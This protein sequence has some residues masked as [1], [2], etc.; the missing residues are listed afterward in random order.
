MK[1]LDMPE[2]RVGTRSKGETSSVHPLPLFT[3]FGKFT[4]HPYLRAVLLP[5][6]SGKWLVGNLL[7][8]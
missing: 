8:D 1:N 5:G 2:P 6:F 3:P 4:L 7:E